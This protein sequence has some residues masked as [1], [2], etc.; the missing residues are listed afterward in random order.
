MSASGQDVLIEAC[1]FSLHDGTSLSTLLQQDD[2]C[3][4]AWAVGESFHN[5]E[6]HVVDSN[7]DGWIEYRVPNIASGE[8]PYPGCCGDEELPLRFSLLRCG[9]PNEPIG[10]WLAYAPGDPRTGPFGWVGADD[11]CNCTGSLAIQRKPS[12]VIMGGA[13]SSFACQAPYQCP[14]DC[15]S[16]PDACQG[17]FP[18]DCRP[19][20]IHVSAN[21]KNEK[22]EWWSTTGLIGQTAVSTSGGTYESQFG[23]CAGTLVYHNSWQDMQSGV[24][25]AG[26]PSGTCD[27]C[28]GMSIGLCELPGG[29]WGC[30]HDGACR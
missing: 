28:S 16:C 9:A 25:P 18:S 21:P 14:A 15:E 29:G 7:N 26:A 5:I 3:V 11:L 13:S 23:A 19:F 24:F 22:L 8:S 17:T 1:A 12:G 30:A 10:G 20:T 6:I 2:A 27:L 4:R